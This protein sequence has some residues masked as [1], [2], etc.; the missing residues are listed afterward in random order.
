MEENKKNSQFKKIRKV[1]I[2]TIIALLVFLLLS[3]IALTLPFVQTKIAKYVTDD[4]NKEYGVNISIDKVAITFFGGVKLKTVLILDHHQDTLIFVNRLNTSLL[5]FKNIANSKLRFGDLRFDNL[6]LN[7]VNYKN[8]KDTNLDL[9]VEAL[10]DGKPGSGNFLMTS[11][12]VYVKKS[13]FVMMD[14][15]R[16]VPKDVDFTKLNAHL[17]NFQI[18]GPDVTAKIA[19]MSFLD[20]RGLFVKDLIADFAYTKRNIKL[21][22][23]KLETENSLVE[24]KVILNY[25]KDNKDFSNFNNKV[26]FD[27]ETKNSKI[28]TND[29]RYFYSEMGKNKVFMLTS[30]VKGTLNDFY[31]TNL[32]LKENNNSIIKGDVNFKNLFPR[33]PGEFFM[34]GDFKKITSNYKDLTELLPNV[35]G[36]K[37]PTS[38]EKLGQFNFTGTAEVTQKYIDADFVMNTALGIIESTLTINNLDNIDNANYKGNVIFDQFEI[39]DLIGQKDIGKVSLNIDVDG[40][41][42][43]QKLLNTTFVGDVYKLNYRGYNYQKIVVD[44]SFKQ[45]VFKGKFFVNDPNLYMDFN[46]LI[47]LGKNEK[48][49]NFNAKIDYANLDKLNIIKDSI[50]VFKGDIAINSKGNDLDNFKGDVVLT[51]AMYQNR[52]DIY[53]ID[54][55]SINSSFDEENE[56]KITVN[57]TDALSGTIVGKYKFDQ[58]KSMIENSIGTLYANY[59]PNKVKKGQ[60]IKFDFDIYSKIIEIFYPDISI[61]KNT[62]IKGSISSESDNFKLDLKSPKITYKENTFDNLLL[63]I[64]NKNPLFKSY[65]QLDSINTKYYKVRDFSMINNIQNDTLYFRT[66]FKGGDKGNDFYNLNLYHTINAENQN[67]VGLQKSEVQFKDYLWFVNEED[68]NQNKIVFD[69]KLQNFN[70]DNI[71]ISHENQS[72]NLN[73][74]LKGTTNKDLILTFKNVNLNKITPDVEKFKFDGKVNGDIYFKQNLQVYQPTSSLEID[75]L[76]LNDIALGKLNLDIKGDES[77]KKFYVRSNLINKNVESFEADGTI[78][79]YDGKTSLDV[80]LRF[81]KFNLGVLGK[82]GGDVITNIRGFASGNA[83]I[84]GDINQLDYNGRLF[85]NDTGL[86][87]PY[88]GVDYS[89]ANNSIV[90]VTENKFIIRQTEIKDSKFD[91]EGQFNGF[92]KH[93]Q[94]GDWEL[95]LNINSKKLLA[96]NTVDSEDAAYYGTAFMNGSASISGPTEGLAIKVNAES[97]NGTSIK[98]PIND[99]ELAEENGYIRFKKPISNNS[100]SKEEKKFNGLELDFNFDILENA[101]IEVILNRDSGHGMKGNGRGTLLFEINTLG[102]FNMYG[103]FQVYKGYY[104]FKYGGLFGKT[105]EVKKYSSIVW[106]GDPMAATLNID[107]VYKTTA[108]PAMLIANPSFNKKVDVEVVIGIKGS[109]MN[110]EP[111]FSIEFPKVASTLR[112]ELQYKLDDK[113]TRQTQALSLL[114]TNSF[115][116]PEGVTQSQSSNLLYEKASS[117]FSDIFSTDGGKVSIAP[118]YV[119]GDTRPGYETDARFGLSLSSKINERITVNGKVGVPVGGVNESAVVG[120]VELQYRVN[121]DGTLNLRVFNREND[122]TYI[123]QGVGYTQGLG[124]SY[125]VD[126]DTFRELI[127]K[128]FN[129]KKLLQIIPSKS[130][131][132]DD[133]VLPDH[134]QFT[135]DPKHPKKEDKPHPN[136]QGLPPEDY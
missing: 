78:E 42:F 52:K 76:M 135:N 70:F 43:T 18:K 71:K 104:N 110:P 12:N 34:K 93:K 90:D 80:D 21:E 123:G 65:V 29:I 56:R 6:Y 35:L 46:G 99:S 61:S 48:I 87:I 17:E 122:V 54:N 49:I 74:V 26:I 4:I 111:E 127:T 124:L 96:L 51:N 75:D 72:V 84:D 130:E 73:G 136:N 91:T 105:F 118:E 57:S 79:V 28:A 33:S 120:N 53:F 116:S 113:D 22:N 83:R 102:K 30:K 9:F 109:L 1:I 69:K 5:D 131:V 129:N 58:L 13:R 133:S 63:Q 98:I 15:N 86:T 103:D 24:G 125:E 126:F 16:E 41:G 59:K 62:K 60:Y 11:K 45:P 100:I 8:E 50:A 68:D 101:D 64:D 82:I 20:H 39:G 81:D 19:E 108:N 85:V 47:D 88:L 66:E 3:A 106:S 128:I 23:L 94:F 10:D 44:G 134:Y 40:K 77:L 119:G 132:G 112:S 115:L 67:V 25:N 97:V 32:Y 37:L 95:D 38:L 14:Y 36:K 92:I 31:A 89:F 114:S 2:R 107:A 117:V 7:I 121:D 55:L 27:I